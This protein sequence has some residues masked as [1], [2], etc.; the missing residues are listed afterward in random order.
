MLSA[1]I[2]KVAHLRHSLQHQQPPWFQVLSASGRQLIQDA[3]T[4]Q[5]H[6][7]TPHLQL[8]HNPPEPVSNASPVQVIS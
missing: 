1:G 4:S 5:L 2:T 3:Q 8:Q 7:I 6:I